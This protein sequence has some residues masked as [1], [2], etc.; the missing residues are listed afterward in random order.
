MHARMSDRV[1]VFLLRTV[2]REG[3]AVVLNRVDGGPP[4]RHRVL[5]GY[6]RGDDSQTPVIGWTQYDRL[7][8]HPGQ[9]TDALAA[10]AQRRGLHWGHTTTSLGALLTE[11]S[12]LRSTTSAG[13]PRTTAPIW[14][15]GRVRV[16]VWDLPLSLVI[17]PQDAEAEPDWPGQMESSITRPEAVWEARREQIKE[18]RRI[19]HD[20][21]QH[22]ALLLSIEAPADGAAIVETVLPPD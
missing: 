21:D 2:L 19:L 16:R 15:P 9:V 22:L 12:D 11:S 1:V 17:T 10:E 6:V 7:Y 13:R 3:R 20:L 4:D 18:V 8:L 14:T 5:L